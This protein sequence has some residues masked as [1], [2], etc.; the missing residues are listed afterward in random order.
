MLGAATLVGVVDGA[1]Y[2]Y[3]RLPHP[4]IITLATLSICRSLALEL[5]VGHTTMR[6]MPDGINAIGS[7]TW[8]IPNSF[9]I[10]LAVALAGFMMT[11]A[12]VWDDGSTVGGNPEAALEMGI[13]VTGVLVST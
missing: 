12:M 11:K 9:F 7:D 1:V 6:G 4:F 2:V 13:Q 8:G 5:S 10:V 3:G